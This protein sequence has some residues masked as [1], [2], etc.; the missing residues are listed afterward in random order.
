MT[1]PIYEIKRD[2]SDHRKVKPWI[3]LKNGEP[4]KY[5]GCRYAQRF[6]TRKDAQEKVTQ[7]IEWDAYL[8][9]LHEQD[10]AGVYEW[11]AGETE[12]IEKFT[13]QLLENPEQWT[14]NGPARFADI[15]Q[16]Q[17]WKDAKDLESDAWIDVKRFKAERRRRMA[18]R[19]EAFKRAGLELQP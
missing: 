3:V 11:N 5:D 4:M 14:F 1:A 18:A 19:A 15:A 6:K 13:Q 10:A 7:D 9:R 12:E 2:E 16:H 8:V 17:H